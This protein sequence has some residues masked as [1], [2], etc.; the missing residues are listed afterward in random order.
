M[1]FFF[2]LISTRKKCNEIFHPINISKNFKTKLML[3]KLVRC[4]RTKLKSTSPPLFSLQ[5]N[6]RGWPQKYLV[7]S[8]GF[9]YQ[10]RV[11]AFLP[12]T[13]ESVGRRRL[14]IIIPSITRSVH[15]DS[16]CHVTCVNKS[17]VVQKRIASENA[18]IAVRFSN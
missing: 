2:F 5:L 15:L 10:E 6:D 7:Y 12:E 8:T 4:L 16:P 14:I 3:K 11:F 1:L 17:T 18:L 9:R 13:R